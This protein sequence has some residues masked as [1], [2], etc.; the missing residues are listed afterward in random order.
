MENALSMQTLFLS[1]HVNQILHVGS[2]SKYLFW[3]LVSLKSAKNV[4]A[5]GLKFWPSH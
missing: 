4:G 1:S 5:V 3:F 2:Y